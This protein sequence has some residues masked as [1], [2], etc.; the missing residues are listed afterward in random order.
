MTSSSSTLTYFGIPG[1]AEPIRLVCVANDIEFNDD[2]FGFDVWP[3]KKASTPYGAVPV[4]TVE[5][6]KG[7]VPQSNA[8]LRYYGKIAGAYPEDAWTAACVD[9]VLDGV[10]ELAG[11]LTPSFKETDD[12]KKK[13]LREK[14]VATDIPLWG[15]RIQRQHDSYGTAFLVSDKLSIADFKLAAVVGWFKSGKVDYVPAD[16]FKDF[17][18]FEQ[19]YN[20]VYSQEKVKNYKA[21]GK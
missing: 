20:A 2:R 13:E 4:L 7:T 17:P 18:I 14:F 1:R 5:G 8:I 6:R 9:S 19:T 15:E 12:A 11:G 21:Q 16:V 10:E 3:T